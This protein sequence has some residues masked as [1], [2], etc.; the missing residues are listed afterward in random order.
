VTRTHDDR[1]RED[2]VAALLEA[3][4]PRPQDA[5]VRE[6]VRTTVHARWQTTVRSRARRRRW[7]LVGHL[8]AAALALA[9]VASLW[10]PREVRAPATPPPTPA[11][12]VARVD[13]V[14]G[15]GP[16]LAGTTASARLRAG[17]LLR[18]GA[19]LVTA[20]GD[21]AALRAPDGVSIRVDEGTRLR[22]LAPA[23]LAL[24]EGRVYVDNPPGPHADRRIVLRTPLGIVRDT[25]TQFE[26]ALEGSTLR[27]RVREGAVSLER[28]V[29]AEATKAGTELRV[30]PDGWV[31]RRAV[32]VY[33]P[34][35][36][37]A[38]SLAPPVD[39]DGR[40]LGEFLSWLTREMGW[41]AAFASDAL[42]S[43][44]PAVVMHGSIAGL[45]PNEARA[46]VLAACG[47]T[48]HLDGR[49]LVIADVTPGR[50]P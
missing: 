38:T 31:E 5:A 48:S 36:A 3:A 6:R 35:W 45:T 28:V 23:D 44:A 46:T 39:I 27:L 37:W 19:V 29:G 1:R 7:F 34:Q 2:D 12:E 11:P 21:R 15:A 8:S 18:A 50:Q 47:L 13:A 25:G 49:T 42:A 10:P 9:V 17:D 43:S 16:A 33:G 20:A 30:S 22:L 41:R 4:G 14:F 24:D 32:S 26:A 40:P